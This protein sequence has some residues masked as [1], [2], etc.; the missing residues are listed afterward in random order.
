MIVVALLLALVIGEVADQVAS[1]SKAAARQGTRSWVAAISPI[2]AQSNALGKALAKLRTSATASGRQLLDAELAQ[3]TLGAHQLQNRL[4]SIAIAP[5]SAAAA[6]FLA[7]AIAGRARAS[8]ALAGAI[9]LATSPGAPSSAASGRLGLAAAELRAADRDYVRFAA[10]LHRED[11]RAVLPKSRWALPSAAWTEAAMVDWA[12]QLSRARALSAQRALSLLAVSLEPRVLKIEG[13][14]TTTLAPV[15]AVHK[16]LPTTTTTASSHSSTSTSSSTS[17]TTTTTT[18]STTTTLQI[19]PAGSVSLV[20]A[21]RAVAVSVVVAATGNL[22]MHGVVVTV[23]LSSGS[24][25]APAGSGSAAAGGSVARAV[26]GALAPGA[27]RYVVV[28]GLRVHAGGAYR[29]VVRA[30]SRDGR[31][32]QATIALRVDG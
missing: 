3:V 1:S 12:A 30:T 14:P 19:P 31:S 4:S 26:V 32:A 6:R 22:T 18:T 25:A 10:L 27:A 5:S 29:L 13:L 23:S 2:V 24:P 9:S 20:Q 8:V 15:S 7:E 21:T 17:T 16:R 11:R 28:H